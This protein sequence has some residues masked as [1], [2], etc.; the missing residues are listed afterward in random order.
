MNRLMTVAVVGLALA[1]TT[2]PAAALAVTGPDL[3]GTAASTCSARGHRITGRV[4]VSCMTAKRVFTHYLDGFASRGWSCSRSRHSCNGSG[5][6]IDEYRY[7]RF[8]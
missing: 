8:S 6:S 1:A 4:G 7:F 3:R 5:L 2:M